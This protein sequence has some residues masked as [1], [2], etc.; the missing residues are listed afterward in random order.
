[1][2]ISKRKLHIIVAIVGAS[3]VFVPNLQALSTWL[4]GHHAAWLSIVSQV[5]GWVATLLTAWPAIVR[6]AKPIVDI[7]E[8]AQAEEFTKPEKNL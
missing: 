2:I 5:V 6:K 3:G 7:V 1:M 4:S 8:A